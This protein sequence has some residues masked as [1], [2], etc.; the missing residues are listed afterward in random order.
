MK[1]VFDKYHGNG[2]DFII[3]DGIN[4][5]FNRINSEKIKSLCN[6]NTGIGSDGFIIIKSNDQC[7]YEM[8]YYN[9]D[10]NIGSFCGNGARC[11]AHFVLRNKILKKVSKFKAF[12]GY[13]F[14]NVQGVRIS[15]S[16]NQVDSYKKIRDDFFIDTGSPHL[17]KFNQNL[18]KLNIKDEFNRAQESKL[19]E[20]GVNV[21]FVSKK[22]KNTY[23]ARTYERGVNAET[24][25]CGTGAVAIALCSKLNY[26][27]DEPITHVITKG[28]KLSVTFNYNEKKFFD[29][30]LL[31]NA[32]F[33]YTGNFNL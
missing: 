18:E 25:S 16:I 11:A 13:H 26:N 17:I 3:V 22:D 19:I 24:L 33:V 5:S 4:N 12:D 9:S 30:F 28:G 14:V 31:G 27:H 7:D 21:N 10:G 1:V 6:R 23:H 8:V 20:G 32:E 15:I 2:N 29:I